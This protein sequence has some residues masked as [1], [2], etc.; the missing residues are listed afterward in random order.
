M[1]KQN[2]TNKIDKTMTFHEIMEKN[3]DAV[4]IL[5]EKGMHCIGCGMAGFETLEQGA[6]AHGL[7]ADELVRELNHEEKPKI[8]NNSKSKMKKKAKRK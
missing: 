3:P 6:M 5:L 8:K 4:M 7:N 1:K 2:K